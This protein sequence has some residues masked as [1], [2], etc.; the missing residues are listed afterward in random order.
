[1][2]EDQSEENSKTCYLGAILLPKV[3][4]NYYRNKQEYTAQVL[5][6]NNYLLFKQDFHMFIC[7]KVHS[8]LSVVLIASRTLQFWQLVSYQM[9]ENNG[10]HKD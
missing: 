1:M 9:F 10:R 5:D 6:Q 7:Q 8:K 2:R 4:S 3:S